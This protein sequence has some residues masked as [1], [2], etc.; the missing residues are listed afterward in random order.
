MGYHIEAEPGV[1]LYVEDLNPQGSRTILFLHGWP[2]NHN[3]YEYQL[4]H[5]PKMG[6]RCLA[7]DTRGFGRSDRPWSGYDY[8]RLAD[9][10]RAVIDAFSL[11]NITLA[12]HSMGG[13][14]ALHYVA[15][16]NGHGVGKLALFGAAAPTFVKRPDFP[17]G[18]MR[19]EVSGLIEMGYNNRPSLLRTFGSM[20]FYQYVRSSLEDWFYDLG[21]QAAGWSTMSCLTTLKDST[22]FGDLARVH[23][24]TLILHGVH[25][26]VCPF[27]LGE[28][29]HQG[30][31]GSILVPF[32]QSGH[33]L[34][35][36]QR[37]KFNSELAGFAS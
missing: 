26:R 21:L 19:D 23:V 17:Y 35:W 37:E 11:S 29:Q 2:L 18:H 16:H 8:N 1:Q 34:F 33:G 7:M 6:F 14:I 32:E 30:I 13:A 20:F 31:R 24:P 27:Q 5:L 12:G 10:V 15:R 22:M 28:A 4:E 36:E 3:A 25:D 9:D